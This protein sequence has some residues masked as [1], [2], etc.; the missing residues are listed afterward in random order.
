MSLPLSLIHQQQ[1]HQLNHNLQFSTTAKK[2]SKVLNYISVYF[3]QL[4][5]LK[6]L[7]QKTSGTDSFSQHLADLNSVDVFYQFKYFKRT[8]VS[9][10]ACQLEINGLCI[11]SHKNYI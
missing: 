2:P 7:I 8:A 11:H 6:L 10:T 5:I 1:A 9:Q 3:M 4:M